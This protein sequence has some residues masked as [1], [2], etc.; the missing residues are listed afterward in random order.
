MVHFQI[1][2]RTL[3]GKTLTIEVASDL[4]IEELKEKISKKTEIEPAE[5]RLIYAGKDLQ[6]DRILSDYGIQKEQTVH[7]MMRMK[8]G[9]NFT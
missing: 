7:L 6:D 5:Q 2:V 8:G 1:F 9:T 4:T 3:T